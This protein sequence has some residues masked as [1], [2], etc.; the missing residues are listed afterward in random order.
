MFPSRKQYDSF[1][2]RSGTYVKLEKRTTLIA[3]TEINSTTDQ[4]YTITVPQGYKATLLRYELWTRAGSSVVDNSL[5][6]RFTLDTKLLYYQFIGGIGDS[7]SDLKEETFKYEDAPTAFSTIS[8]AFN[9]QPNGV[10]DYTAIVSV[11]YSLEPSGE[12]Y[13]I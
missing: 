1:T 4:T 3:S 10:N 13:Y 7:V 8:F 6:T 11:L 5:E 9:V 2:P 12:G